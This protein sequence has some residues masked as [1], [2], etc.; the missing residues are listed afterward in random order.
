MKRICF[1]LL[2]ISIFSSCSTIYQTRYHL[3][4]VYGADY[5][6]A[7][8][9]I[10]G[11]DTISITYSLDGQLKIANN[12][13]ESITIDMANSFFGDDQG[14]KSLYSNSII[15]TTEYDT[16]GVSLNLGGIAS[17]LGAPRGLTNIAYGTNIGGSNTSGTTIQT[18][19]DRFIIIP[20]GSFR[21]INDLSY[22]IG[23]ELHNGK[24]DYVISYGVGNQPEKLH[25]IHDEIIFE[26]NVVATNVKKGMRAQ[27]VEQTSINEYKTTMWTGGGLLGY[28]FGMIGAGTVGGG[29]IAGIAALISLAF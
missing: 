17:S 28:T 20:S 9:L 14:M 5:T 7:R 6:N 29:L 16:K 2:C 18:F 23:K 13:K 15:S 11:N 26:T 3:A 24:F 25:S 10:S 22:A 4:N 8:E 21:T 27:G 19:Q 12:S 1:I